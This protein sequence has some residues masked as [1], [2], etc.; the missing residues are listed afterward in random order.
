[1]VHSFL[2]TWAGRSV[3]T[4]TPHQSRWV[5]TSIYNII[6]LAAQPSLPILRKHKIANVISAW[7]QIGIIIIK[8]TP[9]T[10]G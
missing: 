8:Q 5:I 6:S 9:S 1:M 2:T 10:K 3:S 7:P 4:H